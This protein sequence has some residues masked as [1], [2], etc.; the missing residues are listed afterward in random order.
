[1]KVKMKEN[2]WY[3][4]LVF[5][6]F[7]SL[8]LAQQ[9]PQEITDKVFE[10]LKSGEDKDYIGEPISQLEHALQCAKLAVDENMDDETILAALFHDIGH[11]CAYNAE[12]MAGYGVKEHEKIGAKF[13]EELSFPDKIVQLV[14]SHVD[15]KRYLTFKNPEY[16]EKL[17]DAS[18]RTLQFQGGP[19]L[20]KEA[21]DFENDPLFRLK[22]FVRS[23]DEKAKLPNFQAPDLESYRN[24]C[25]KSLE[26][27]IPVRSE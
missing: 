10:I 19:M 20:A 23:C 13:L 2:I 17:S 6:F 25:I 12:S 9:S 26:K 11:L 15:A 4:I 16:F 5:S 1:M 14:K 7:S 24:M 3:K 21:Q 18:K 27:L 8:C 22:I